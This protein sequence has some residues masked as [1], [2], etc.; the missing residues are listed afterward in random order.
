M[1]RPLLKPRGERV[2]DDAYLTP[3]LLAR[4]ICR[5]LQRLGLDRDDMPALARPRRIL[6]PNAGGGSFVAGAREVWLGS[7]ILAEDVDAQRTEADRD[8]H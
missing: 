3:P 8:F 4:A 2:A 5:R 6:E 7:E 1:S